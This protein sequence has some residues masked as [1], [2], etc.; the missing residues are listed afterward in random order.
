M[1]YFYKVK[2]AE[3]MPRIHPLLL[4]LMEVYNETEKPPNLLS[5]SEDDPRILTKK[6]YYTSPD[7]FPPLEIHSPG[8]NGMSSL[9]DHR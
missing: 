3:P 5:I 1:D 6:E 8:Q 9:S 7:N 2:D 4:S